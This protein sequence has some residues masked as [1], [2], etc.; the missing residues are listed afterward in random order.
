MNAKTLVIAATALGAMS[1]G[2]TPTRQARL[3]VAGYTGDELK[4]FPVLVRVSSEKIAGFSYA[5]CAAK[6][7][8]VSFTD[9][10]GNPLCHEIDTWNPAGESLVWVKIP[11]FASE[12]KFYMRWNDKTPPKNEP[13]KTWSA[14]YLGVWHLGEAKDTAWNASPSGWAMRAIPGGNAAE[15]VRYA[16]TDAPV[17]FARTIS[18]SGDAFLT[19][20]GYAKQTVGSFFTMSGWVRLTSCVSYGRIFGQKAAGANSGW[21][22]E[23]AGTDLTQF[24]VRG[25]GDAYVTAWA[26]PPGLTRWTHLA[27]VF[28]ND[29]VRVYVDGKCVA[30][31]SVSPVT[32]NGYRLVFGNYLWGQTPVHGAF[33]ECRLMRRVATDDWVKAEYATVKGEGFL[34]YGKA[35]DYKP[36]SEAKAE[37]K[38]KAK[39]KAGK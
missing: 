20:D 14:D 8:D 22:V 18:S 2:A 28:E 12:T 15:C 23:M 11:K 6:G 31:G 32:P 9:D 3:K 25:S 39:A 13:A 27:F 5:D 21:E 29:N 4:D 24:R 30:S 37:A 36:R 19:A 35:K 16:D 1:L 26:P 34:S 17:G 7:A 10:D 33:D 38:A